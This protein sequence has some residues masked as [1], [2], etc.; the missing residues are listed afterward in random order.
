MGY[1]HKLYQVEL[2]LM[3]DDE[4]QLRLLTDQIREEAT[5]DNGW[6]RLCKLLLK[7][8]QFIKAEELCDALLENESDDTEKAYYYVCLGYV[9]DHKGDYAKAIWYYEKALEIEQNTL[10]SNHPS[11]TIS[12]GNIGLVYNNMGEYSKALSFCEKA[13]EI[14]HETLPSNHP[15]LATSYNNIGL[16]Y[17]NM[18]EYSKAI[19]FCEKAL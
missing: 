5:G 16:V 3:S 19:S 17:D 7:I 4:Q 10:P 14:F 6:R 8:G 1:D 2:Q 12:Y 18:G 13:L 11:L 9:Q 15:S